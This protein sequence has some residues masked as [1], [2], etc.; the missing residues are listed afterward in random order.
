MFQNPNATSSPC[1]CGHSF[2]AEAKAG[3]SCQPLRERATLSKED[4]PPLDLPGLRAGRSPSPPRLTGSGS[5]SARRSSP[6]DPP[7]Q[8]LSGQPESHLPFRVRRRDLGSGPRRISGAA[9]AP[10]GCYARRDEEERGGGLPTGRN[11][12]PAPQPRLPSGLPPGPDGFCC[13]SFPLLPARRRR[14]APR[15]ASAREQRA[16]EPSGPDPWHMLCQASRPEAS[17][18]R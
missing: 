11:T 12:T 3:S 17:K 15:I 18:I 16:S 4:P 7:P 2:E 13:P 1:G 8:R 14:A 6:E 5:G 9:S 10:W